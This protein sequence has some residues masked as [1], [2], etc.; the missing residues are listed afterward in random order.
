MTNSASAPLAFTLTADSIINISYTNVYNGAHTTIP[1]T[2][3][4]TA[5][6]TI[7]AITGSVDYVVPA[8]SGKGHASVSR[9]TPTAVTYTGSFYGDL[10]PNWQEPGP[11]RRHIGR[12][13]SSDRKVDFVPVGVKSRFQQI[14]AVVTQV[15]RQRLKLLE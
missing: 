5:I 9:S 3:T 11:I 12:V 2:S 1:L 10:R 6:V 4:P 13:Q 7:D 14:R 8:I 15:S